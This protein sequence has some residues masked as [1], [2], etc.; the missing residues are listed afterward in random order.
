VADST[1]P[2]SRQ[3]Y[4]GPGYVHRPN[5]STRRRPPLTVAPIA[6]QA[7]GPGRAAQPDTKGTA[8][9]IK[10]TAQRMGTITVTNTR[11]RLQDL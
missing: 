9:W 1:S 8:Y 7:P 3:E 2:S 6:A 4:T 11:K 10:V 5:E